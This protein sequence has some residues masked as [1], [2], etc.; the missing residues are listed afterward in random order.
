MFQMNLGN[1]SY[2]TL[3]WQV[4]NDEF[5][6][7]II[8]K[9]QGGC[10]N[11]P[12]P[13]L[14]KLTIHENN[15]ASKVTFPVPLKR[16]IPDENET[17]AQGPDQGPC[18]LFGENKNKLP[19]ATHSLRSADPNGNEKFHE[20]HAATTASGAESETP[21]GGYNLRRQRSQTEK[22]VK[23]QMAERRDKRLDD[24]DEADEEFFIKVDNEMLEDLANRRSAGSNFPFSATI[25]L[26]AFRQN[27]IRKGTEVSD[28][29]IRNPMI[30]RPPDFAATEMLK[31][32][33]IKLS[34]P[35]STDCTIICQGK[36]LPSHKYILRMRSKVFEVMRGFYFF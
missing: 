22:Q 19:P 34:D 16:A 13:V 31:E 3:R 18:Q 17:K 24:R 11:M 10:V 33:H 20:S 9:N 4:Q 35:S 2:L 23:L 30:Q 12:V 29:E 32:L 28:F 14:A 1:G 21:K 7:I 27:P 26:M 6:K 36:R 25:T 15:R 5:V 8:P